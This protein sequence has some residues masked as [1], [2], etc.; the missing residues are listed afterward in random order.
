MQSINGRIFNIKPGYVKTPEDNEFI[1]IFRN[2]DNGKYYGRKSD[3]SNELIGGTRYVESVTGDGVNNIDPFNPILTF[4]TTEEI[5]AVKLNSVL[6]ITDDC[7]INGWSSYT[8]KVITQINLGNIYLINIYISGISISGLASI[9]LPYISSINFGDYRYAVSNG[10]GVNGRVI[11][12]AG[13]NLIDWRASASG[14]PFAAMG[15][16][17]ISGQIWIPKP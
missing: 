16:K 7:I 9:Q 11:I 10:V 13:S 12:S 2:K 8:T 4:P 5:G 1:T 14:A 6:D 17:L 15:T 3:G